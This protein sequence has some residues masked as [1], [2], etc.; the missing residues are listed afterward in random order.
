[1]A[2]RQISATT[3]TE[4]A[5]AAEATTTTTTTTT[6]LVGGRGVAA[7]AVTVAV[8][9]RWHRNLRGSSTHGRFTRRGLALSLPATTTTVVEGSG[10]AGRAWRRWRGRDAAGVGELGRDGARVGLGEGDGTRLASSGDGTV[11][12][13][14]LP[15]PP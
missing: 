1:M 9:A 4:A 12:V 14:K 13:V 11:R 5:E 8:T 7:V 3:I 15:P 10:G 6:T 2:G